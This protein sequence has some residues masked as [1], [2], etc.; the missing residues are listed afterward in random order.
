MAG[1]MNAAQAVMAGYDTTLSRQWRDE[2]RVWRKA[3]LSWRDREQSFMDYE[4]TIMCARLFRQ[5]HAGALPSCR[6]RVDYKA[7]A[8]MFRAA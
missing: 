5:L 7:A 1:I 4:R 2:D 6:Q 8:L 3:D